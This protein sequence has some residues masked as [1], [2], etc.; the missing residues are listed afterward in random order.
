V[1][2]NAGNKVCPYFV[3]FYPVQEM[4]TELYCGTVGFINI[5]LMKAV[6]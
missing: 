5:G 6:F 4:S 1:Q 2:S 3:H